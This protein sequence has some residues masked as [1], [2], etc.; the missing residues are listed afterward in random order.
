MSSDRVRDSR[1]RTSSKRFS[2][3]GGRETVM[4]S[5]VRIDRLLSNTWYYDNPGTFVCQ[6]RVRRENRIQTSAI[7]PYMP[8]RLQISQVMKS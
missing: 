8:H 6:G 4:I 7:S 1:F 2:I 5:V 3:S